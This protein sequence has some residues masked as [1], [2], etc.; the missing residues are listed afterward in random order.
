MPISR[1]SRLSLL[2]AGFIVAC[3][4]DRATSPAPDAPNPSSPVAPAPSPSPSPSSPAAF[5]Q[6]VRGH[7]IEK[8]GNFMPGVVGKSTTP[9]APRKAG[10]PDTTRKT[11]PLSVPVHV[12]RGAIAR[13]ERHDPKSPAY[14]T[15][16]TSDAN[17]EYRVALPAG[18]YTVVAEIDGKLYLNSFGAGAAAGDADRWSTVDVTPNAFAEWNIEDTSGATF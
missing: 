18:T 15:T 7:V 3:G 6:G 4:A 11:T 14:V 12:Y 1:L 13:T 10:A 2:V 17:G 5:P 8:T 16:V 9:N